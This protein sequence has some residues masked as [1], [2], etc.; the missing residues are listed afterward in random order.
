MPAREVTVGGVGLHTGMVVAVTL[1]PRAGAVRLAS[2]GLRDAITDLTVTGT[3]RSTTVE[4]HGGALRVSTVEH[5][6]SAL[7]GLDIRE[8]LV[9]R[10]DGPELP[11]LDGGASAW[12][13][14]LR[15]LD[16]P[17]GS[18][19]PPRLWVRRHTVIDIGSSRYEFAPAD[20][21]EVE[22]RIDFG[23]SRL[24]ESA[25]WGGDADDFR[26]RIAPARTFAR[27]C[28]LEP[29]AALGLARHV[30]PASVVVIAQDAIHAV[31]A[32]FS[33]DEP[34]RHKLLDL[35]GDLYLWGGPPRGRV[36]ATRPG[37]T[38]NARAMRRAL[39]EGAV[40]AR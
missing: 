1:I 2:G 38:A 27:A 37:H 19:R 12:C 28:D 7:A 26:E 10:V 18:P 11:L 5:L 34:A 3:L 6:F 20:G 30:D 39:D 9:L 32:P 8:G 25:R 33:P 16:L 13:D 35:M 17:P 21:V 24:V 36:R 40:V 29:L 31:G 4:G 15:Q 22:V 23:D 14:A